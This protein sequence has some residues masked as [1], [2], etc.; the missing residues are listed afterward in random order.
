MPER[1]NHKTE[2]QNDISQNQNR[3]LHDPG[4]AVPDYGRSAQTARE[5][6][7]EVNKEERS[8]ENSRT[9]TNENDTLGIP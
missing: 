9:S 2:E 6:S 3:S 4:A 8:E 7:K 5:Q 1:T